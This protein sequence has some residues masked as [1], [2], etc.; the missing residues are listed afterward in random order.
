MVRG[1]LPLLP[2][3][4]SPRLAT[5][6]PSQVSAPWKPCSSATCCTGTPV[7]SRL[8]AHPPD[9]LP[10]RSGLKV[11]RRRWLGA[12]GQERQIPGRDRIRGKRLPAPQPGLCRLFASRVR[13]AAAA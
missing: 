9:H 6:P 7:C 8:S 3:S 12:Q 5:A 11:L 10:G 13:V 2:P 1:A 4:Q